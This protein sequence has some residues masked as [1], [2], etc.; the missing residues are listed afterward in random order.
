MEEYKSKYMSEEQEE[1]EVGGH[2]GSGGDKKIATAGRK[3]FK[4]K[5]LR[6]LTSIL[7]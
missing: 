5:F 7:N 2:E 3:H 1:G 6:K 4:P